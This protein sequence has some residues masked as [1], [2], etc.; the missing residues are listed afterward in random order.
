MRLALLPLAA[1]ISLLAAPASYVGDIAISSVTERY[2]QD[3]V[4]FT[5]S[6][7]QFSG[8]GN[9]GA[10]Q[11]LN[12]KMREK[13]QSALI[14]AKA[15]GMEL[16]SAEGTGQRSAE[17]IYEYVVKRNS[18]GIVSL[19]FSDYLYAGGANGLTTLSGMTFSAATGECYSLEGLFREGTSCRELIDAEIRRQMEERDLSSQLISPFEGVQNNDCFYLTDTSLVIVFQEMQY[20]PHSMGSVEFS[21]PLS[22]LETCLKPEILLKK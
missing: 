22:R 20:F 2:Q 21:V 5:G 4:S 9:T 12:V 10:Q 7:P 18:G 17:G 15:A 8:I 13:E 1:L 3:S 19:L 11:K 6:Y 14:R 16:S